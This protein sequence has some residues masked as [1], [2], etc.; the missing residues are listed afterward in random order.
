M[1]SIIASSS[2]LGNTVHIALISVQLVA[3]E[4]ISP[5]AP[6][7]RHREASIL[8]HRSDSP[9]VNLGHSTVSTMNLTIS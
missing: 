1:C 2:Q 5:C 9:L 4:L 6:T 8:N 7:I 3:V